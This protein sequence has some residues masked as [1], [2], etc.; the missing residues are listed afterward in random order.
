MK[1]GMLI[2]IE[3]PDGAG[4]STQ[5]NFIKEYFQEKNLDTVFL[6][7]PGSTT[8]GEDIRKIILSKDNLSMSHTCEMFLYAAARAQMV[9]EKIIPAIRDKKIVICDRYIDSSLAYQGF[10][11]KLGFETVRDINTHATKNIL[12]KLTIFLDV[13]VKATKNRLEVNGK[14]ADR[15]EN[16]GENFHKMVLEGYRFIAEEYKERI[17]KVDGSLSIEEVRLLIKNAL[18]RIFVD[19]V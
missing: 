18:D 11:R 13:D 9:E 5:L 2:S 17:L 19:E 14:E 10:G 3:G 7:E 16:E 12:P 15:I 4:K 6:R 1:E 8:I